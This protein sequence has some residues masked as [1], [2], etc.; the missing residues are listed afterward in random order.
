LGEVL[1]KYLIEEEKNE[2]SKNS[3]S[4]VWDSSQKAEGWGERGGER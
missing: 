1:I 3:V 4:V 2:N